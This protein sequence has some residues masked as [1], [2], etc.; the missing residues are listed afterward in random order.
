MK[1]EVLD[2]IY[3]FYKDHYGQIEKQEI[4]KW[5]AVVQ[6]QK[7][8]D[9]DASDFKKMLEKSLSKTSNLMSAGSYYPHRMIIWSAEKEPETVRNLFRM[10]YDLTSDLKERIL[11]FRDGINGIIERNK[12]GKV[13]KS[14][15]DDRAVMVYLNMRYPDKY[16]LYKYSMFVKFAE[17]IDYAEIPKAGDIELIFLFESMC[18]MILKKVLSDEE[19][20]SMYE[21]RKAKYYD[22]AYH[23]LVQDIIYACYYY[24]DPGYLESIEH[25][26]GVKAFELEVRSN[27]VILKGNH[28]DYLE[29]AKVQKRIGDAGEEF[30][31]QYE[32]AQVKKYKL[33]KE[34]KVRMVAKLDGD[35]LGYDILS[36]S[37]DGTEK[38]IEVKT[39]NGLESNS[40]FIT[41]NELAM[42]KKKSDQY[43]LYRVYDFDIDTM[44]G[45]IS[46]R[47]GSLEEL[48]TSAQTYKVDFK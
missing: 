6:F 29:E 46:I 36:Y 41:A 28:V 17:L 40:F 3:Q 38:Y 33:G 10:L 45:K 4:Y 22:P 9:I 2:S 39:T 23:L 42:S 24:E 20:L 1:N 30:V 19:L 7:S 34:K 35:G 26:V 37:K 43:Y 12:E 47:Q 14:Y 18:E 32:R 15:Q 8:W 11:N 25:P 21:E 31:F 16:Y 48:C 13:S 5:K 27:P 44:I